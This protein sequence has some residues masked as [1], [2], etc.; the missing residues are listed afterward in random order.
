MLEMPEAAV[1]PFQPA[2]SHI[3]STILVRHVAAA[4]LPA[5]LIL[6][7]W[8]LL[9][10]TSRE[11]AG[12]GMPDLP[13]PLRSDPVLRAIVDSI[14]GP[15]REGAS[16]P[17]LWL[18]S[19]TMWSLMGTA[20]ML[21]CAL[22]AW[23]G[24]LTSGGVEGTTAG[25]YSFLAGYGAL[26]GLAAVAAASLGTL[27]RLLPAMD[28]TALDVAAAASLV[29]C[30]L[31]QA[32]WGAGSHRRALPQQS[33]R[34]FRAGWRYA[35]GSIPGDAAPMALMALLPASAG[36]MDMRIAVVL[37]L[38][39]LV[40]R[41]AKSALLDVTTGGAIALVGLAWGGLLLA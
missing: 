4:V 36:T 7:A 25:A 27:L 37:A 26:W 3:R 32:A 10:F 33:Q 38:A 15:G 11:F 5:S 41:L 2:A 40:L 6:V 34:R 13:L 19:F 16:L 14:C 28:P 29:L 20:M 17:A 39:M 9:A 12:G 31:T 8:C 18:Q 21:P 23:D 30:G 22:P 24:L 35:L 1:R